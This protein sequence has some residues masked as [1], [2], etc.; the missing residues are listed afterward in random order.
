VRVKPGELNELQERMAEVLR[1]TAGLR[2]EFRKNFERYSATM[3]ETSG[4]VSTALQLLRDVSQDEIEA[5]LRYSRSVV[6]TVSEPL[7]ILTR[8]LRFVSA[9]RAFFDMTGLPPQSSVGKVFFALGAGEWDIPLLRQAF[10]NVLSDNKPFAGLEVRLLLR[11]DDERTLLLS[12]SPLSHPHARLLLLAIH[13]ITDRKQIEE[14]LR[15]TQRDLEH[16]VIARTAELAYVNE[17]L[18][19]EVEQRRHAERMRQQLLKQVVTVQE[20]ERRRLSREL[21]DQTGQQL[22]AL[23][24]GLKSLR[25]SNGHKDPHAVARLQL[26]AEE[27]DQELDHMAVELRPPVLDDIGLFPAISQ[28]VEQWSERTGIPV[29][30]HSSGGQRKRLTRDIETTLYRVTQEALTNV[31]KHAQASHVSVILEQKGDHVSL[32]IEDDGK[33]LDRSGETAAESRGKLGLLG[34]QERMELVGGTLQVESAPGKGTSLFLR[35]PLTSSS[36]GRA[37]GSEYLMK[38]SGE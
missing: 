35:I 1:E 17:A 25:D 19:A 18:L 2:S 3:Q 6:E 36:P 14:E 15:K 27:I 37:D 8:S 28:H 7:I 16:R 20:D 23:I 12:G 38:P 9:N 33:G 31:L 4:R 34:V 32:I 29:D 26:L 21:H 24:L 13:D 5:A 22:T 11:P 10:G 30:F